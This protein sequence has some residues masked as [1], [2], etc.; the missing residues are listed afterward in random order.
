MLRIVRDGGGSAGGH[1]RH[2][3]RGRACQ[4]QQPGRLHARH[5]DGVPRLQHGPRRRAFLR[6]LV[7]PGLLVDGGAV[8]L[9]HLARGLEVRR[10]APDPPAAALLRPVSQ[11]RAAAVRRRLLARLVPHTLGLPARRRAG[12]RVAP[13][14]VNDHRQVARRSLEERRPG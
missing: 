4:L 14:L 13:R 6:V 11:L 8:L 10:A 12:G 3:E 9:V 1:L 5:S 7:V 2:V